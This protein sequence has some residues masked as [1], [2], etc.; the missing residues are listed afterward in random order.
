MV[1]LRL[2]S[3]GLSQ[4]I[5]EKF[6]DGAWHTL[7]EVLV[8]CGYLIPPE[9]AIRRYKE[10]E[11]KR[12]RVATLPP[13]S[14][15]IM[16]GRRW[17]LAATVKR[18]GAEPGETSGRTKWQTFRLPKLSAY[19]ILVGRLNGSRKLTEETVIEIMREWD[20]RKIE[21]E[22]DGILK[23]TILE[24]I[25]DAYGTVKS[26]VNAIVTRRSWK[27]V[28]WPSETAAE[29]PALKEE[30]DRDFFFMHALNPFARGNERTW[31]HTRD[32][33]YG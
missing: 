9:I 17:T 30:D 23:T 16:A 27:H 14:E 1:D 24:E 13:Q 21:V 28:P 2:R 3:R 15:R 25:G 5:M 6:S 12:E 31:R 10:S 32:S 29:M 19:E 18:L 33:S 4:A 11:S 7:D 26:N 22:R 8:E 20:R